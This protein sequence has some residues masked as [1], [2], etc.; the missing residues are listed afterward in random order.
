[1]IGQII[2]AVGGLATSYLDGKVAVQKANA[3]IKVKQ[4]TGEIDWD[5]EAIKA[6]QNSWKDEWITLLFSIPLILA[7]C[8]DWG[9]KLYRQVL[10]HLKLCLPGISIL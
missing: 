1:M 10:Q 3:E 6:T 7:F 8:G 4:A 2:G 9:I 5:I